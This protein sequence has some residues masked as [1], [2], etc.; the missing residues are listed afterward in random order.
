MKFTKTDILK[1]LKD[2]M[3]IFEKEYSINKIGLFGSYSRDEANETSDIDLIYTLKDGK[4]ITYF[5]IYN[6][7][8]K[9]ENH[10]KKKVDLVNFKYMNPIIKFK[11][12]ND[13]IYV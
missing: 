6:L 8:K 7:E 10:F 5:Q 4:K 1:Y 2:N 11:S 13:I 12:L 9:L 3:P